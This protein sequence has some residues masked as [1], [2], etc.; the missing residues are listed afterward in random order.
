M[1]LREKAEALRRYAELE[2]TEL[3]ELC[4]ALVSV[5]YRAEYASDDFATALEKELTAQL[6]NFKENATIIERE[7]TFTRKV[8][9]LEWA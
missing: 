4:L 1:D 9:G 3:G 5:A 6:D 8:A 2:G 7:E